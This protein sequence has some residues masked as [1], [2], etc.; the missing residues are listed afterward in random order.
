M[1]GY[2]P[3]SSYN[4]KI[5]EILD[6]YYPSALQWCSFDD[7]PNGLVNIDICK[8]FPSILILNRYTIP[9]YT[10]H[11][12]IE[13]PEGKQKMDNDIGI[14]Y[15]ELNQNGEFYI[16][17][18][19]IKQ[20]G[21]Q[22]KFPN[23]F[24][25]V[26]LIDFFI[27]ECGMSISNIKYKLIARH[28]IK[29]DTFKDF[30]KYIFKTFPEQ[31]ANKM[32]NSF[33]GDLGRKYNRT[34]YGFTCQ[35]LETAQNIWIQGLTDGKNITIDNFEDLYLIREQK[36]DRMLSDHTG[37]NRYI[38]S[39][40]ILQCLQLLKN[41]WT[42]HSELYSINTDGFYMTNP[43][44]SYRNKADVKFVVKHIGEPFVTNGTPNYFDKHY[45]ENTLDEK[46]DLK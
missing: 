7:Q 29:N 34:N 5:R 25:H 15:P 11:D 44:H 39:Q 42:K 24:Y 30:M 13:K 43:K 1:V 36:I 18:F 41:N 46:T 8:Q 3:E 37:I 33:I 16:D 32:A 21:N 12:N 6:R 17:T 27:Y 23:G 10:I 2:I 9:I 14:Y 35:I 28:G 40:S 38:I 20:F 22:I 26:S 45:R 19:T 31:I 4:N